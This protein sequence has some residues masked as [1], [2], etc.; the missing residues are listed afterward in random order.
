MHGPTAF[1]LRADV[2]SLH[3]WGVGTRQIQAKSSRNFQHLSNAKDKK[4]VYT[5]G[6]VVC[7]NKFSLVASPSGRRAG[8]AVRRFDSLVRSE[9][10]DV[11]LFLCAHGEHT[12][13]QTARYKALPVARRGA[14]LFLANRIYYHWRS[15]KIMGDA[16][17]GSD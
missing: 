17:H 9:V 7:P 12:F 10:P 2:P 5:I 6:R 13:L 8:W 15:A 3:Y 1:A 4:R 14:Q 11:F 16:E